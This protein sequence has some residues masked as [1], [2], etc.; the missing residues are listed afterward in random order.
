MLVRAKIRSASIQISAGNQPEEATAVKGGPRKT[1]R[2]P[3]HHR[4]VIKVRVMAVT[5]RAFSFGGWMPIQIS[6]RTPST[7]MLA[8]I[9][10]RVGPNEKG[11]I[12]VQDFP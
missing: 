4:T 2:M 6:S 8:R 9:L 1:F 11:P 10:K 3:H 12:R 5:H 7:Q